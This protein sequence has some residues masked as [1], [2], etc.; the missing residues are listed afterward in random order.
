MID[1]L[2]SGSAARMKRLP[3][4]ARAFLSISH[5][6]RAMDPREIEEL[7]ARIERLKVKQAEIEAMQ[8]QMADNVGS[9]QRAIDAEAAMMQRIRLGPVT[10]DASDTA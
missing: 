2:L 6:G 1:S 9:V 10:P 3:R 8:R 4:F 7:I 5:E